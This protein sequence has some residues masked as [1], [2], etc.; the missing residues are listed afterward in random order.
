MKAANEGNA[1]IVSELIKH[2]AN[3]HARTSRQETVL[4]GACNKGDVECVRQLL[5]VDGIDVNAVD[6]DGKTALM[7]AAAWAKD[8]DVVSLLI[9]H[10]A[11]VKR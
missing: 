2:G 5:A 4:M 9:E 3:V 10:G 7:L 1:D 8:A 11:N 6:E